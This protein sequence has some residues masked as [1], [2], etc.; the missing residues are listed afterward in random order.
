MPLD[1]G[2]ATMR[3][4]FA[5]V[6]DGGASDLEIGALMAA[7]TA[8]E[9][10][11]DADGFAEII[12][13]LSDAMRERMTPLIVDADSAPIVVLPNYG[14]ED[15]F[16]AT[17]LVALLLR[18]MGVRVLVHGAVETHGGLFNSSILRELGILPATN[19]GQ[20]E[21]RFSEDGLVVLP[22][23]LFSPGL[24]AMLS[25][26]NRLGICTPG[27]ALANMLMPVVASSTRTL[28]V[29]QIAPWLTS[30]LIDE[31]VV[32][33][34]PVLCVAAAGSSLGSVGG[35]ACLSFRDAESGAAWQTLFDS[36]GISPARGM[37]GTTNSGGAPDNHD[38]R[39]WAT[40]TRQRLNGGSGL[41][42]MVGH[43]F[44]CCLYGCGYAPD[45]NQAKAIVAMGAVNLAAA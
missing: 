43:L 40:W 17:P 23:T 29:L 12:L 31:S 6:L 7:S 32:L 24:A 3:A 41:P 35:P 45:L 38:P 36:D 25:L 5:A 14:N 21:Q 9:A 4:A 11:R 42:M 13:G 30:R 33:E 15:A 2:P 20:A 39:A 8:L 26:R 28:H 16:P 37:Q 1:V 10:R 18:R 19:R 27:H 44:A 22:V 34:S